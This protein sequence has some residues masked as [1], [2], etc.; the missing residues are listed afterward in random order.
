LQFFCVTSGCVAKVVFEPTQ[1]LH[2]WWH[3]FCAGSECLCMSFVIWFATDW[4]DT[5]FKSG[6]TAWLIL[7]FIDSCMSVQPILDRKVTCHA[8]V[9][10][11]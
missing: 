7:G 11:A 3:S 10:V 6:N 4:L 8:M 9:E 5:F 2:D 1:M